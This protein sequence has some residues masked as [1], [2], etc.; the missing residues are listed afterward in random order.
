MKKKYECNCL[1]WQLRKILLMMKFLWVFIIVGLVSANAAESYSQNTRID[2]NIKNA[3]LKSILSQIEEKTEFYFFY[4]NEEIKNL[5]NLT[6]QANKESISEVLNKLLADKGFEYEIFDRYILIQKA[7]NN[8]HGDG[9]SEQTKQIRGKVT[10]LKGLPL[11][12][13]SVLIKGTTK[14]TVTNVDGEYNIRGNSENDI[15]VFSFIGMATQEIEVGTKSV[16]DI[17]MEEAN[18]GI[19]EVVVTALGIERDRK[20]LGYAIS[21]IKAGDLTVAGNAQNPVL[22]LYGKAAG[23][24]I[25]QSTSGVL[26]GIKLNIRGTA[27][28]ESDAN[29]NRP[30]YVVDGVPI[31]DEDTG[32]DVGSFDYGTGINDINPDDIESIE[33]LKGAKASVLYGSEGANGVVLITTKSGGG[34]GGRL[35]VNASFQVS[36]EQPLT[37]VELQ[38]KYGSGSNIYDVKTIV[39]G[40]D[41][42][43]Y[44]SNSLN[45]GPRFDSS[46]KRIW[47]DGEARPYVAHPNN[48][49]FLFSNG[50]NKQVNVAIDNSGAFGNVRLSFTN[51][52][53]DGVEDNLWQDKKVISF[54][55]NFNLSKK[56]T[57][58]TKANIY[59][60]DTHNR[61]Q[62]TLSFFVNGISRDAPFEEFIRNKDYLYNDPTDANYG[63]KVD[64]EDAGYPTGYYALKTFASYVWGRERNSYLDEKFHLIGSIRPTY[65]ITDWLSVSGQI[66]LDYTN[67]DYTTEES[68]TLVDPELVGG[69]YSKSKR[70]TTI[71]EYKG[72]INFVKSFVDDRLDVVGLT[73]ISYK[74]EFEDKMSVATSDNGTST[75]FIYP[76]WYSLSNQLS[77]GW[78]SSSSMSSV[79]SYGWGEN[80]LYGLFGVLTLTWD[81]KYTVEL[82]A[83]NDWSSTLS[84]DNNSY[85]YPGVAFTWDATDLMQ[86]VLPALQFGKIRASWANVGRSPSRYYAYNSLSAS[87]VTGSSVSSITS[88]SS[89]FAGDIKPERKREFEVGTEMSFFR[90]NRLKLDAS[91]YTNSVYDQ[92]MSVPL[93]SSTGASEIKINAGQVNNWGYEI[94]MNGAPILTKQFRWDLNFTTA[95][96]FSKVI[97]LYSGITQ[98]TISSMRG[99]VNVLAREGERIGNIYGTALAVDPDGNRIV[100]S[101]GTSYVLDENNETKVGNVFPKFMGGFSTTFQYKGFSLYAGFD[102]SFGASMY[103]QTNQWLYYNGAS[104]QSLAHRDAEHGGLEYTEDGNTYYDGIILDGV[105]ETSDGVYEKNTTIASVSSYY[106]TFVSW[107]GESINAVDLKYKNNYVKL[108]ELSLYYQVPKKLVQKLTLKNATVGVFARNIGY[109]YK[110]IPNL[111]AEAY[112][113]T[114]SYYEAS[115]IPSTRTLGLKLSVGF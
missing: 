82:N 83:R 7:S 77:D 53:Y 101:D 34:A 103:S 108:R 24:T 2:L 48:Y 86:N 70:N 80:C 23:V 74:N 88:S 72:F 62:N 19:D 27:G 107:A 106:S 85:F 25:R 68:V 8:K 90:R 38:N 54:S 63:Y 100:S 111:D 99:N 11:P 39:D 57:V 69:D 15:L 3:T 9:L 4:K 52:N 67:T 10:D 64:F 18:L 87:T 6:I 43:R 51:M 115:P 21:T 75:S 31:F 50:A 14:G 16:I 95:N 94:Q 59:K 40:E 32:L 93:S 37:Y 105:V 102:Y 97:K 113:G 45:F 35:N 12:G 5:T 81:N 46:E 66:S 92:I 84:P 17:V 112:M 41:Y 44:N 91:F 104:K 110:T 26:G 28:L 98:K 96:Q 58:E 79:R 13:V 71:Q 89:L 73:G 56:F 49:D 65:R 60:I 76:N 114:S 36:V 29:D 1:K 47:W 30:L 109:L 42:P 61:S 20:S 33:I 55:G 78:A 22:S